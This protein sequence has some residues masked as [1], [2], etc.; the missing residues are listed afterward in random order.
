MPVPETIPMALTARRH[1]GRVSR[2]VAAHCPPEGVRPPLIDPFTTGGGGARA[3]ESG[4]RIVA[5]G[6]S[7]RQTGAPPKVHTHTHPRASSSSGYSLLQHHPFASVAPHTTGTV[8]LVPACTART[9]P[10]TSVP[11]PSLAPPLLLLLLPFLVPSSSLGRPKR[12]L[13]T[14]A[15][16]SSTCRP[17]SR[18]THHHA[19]RHVAGKRDQRHRAVEAIRPEEPARLP[20]AAVPRCATDRQRGASSPGPHTGRPAIARSRLEHAPGRGSGMS[21]GGRS[22]TGRESATADR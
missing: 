1:I 16:S 14:R 20:P 10:G 9:R 21:S 13:S 4:A 15:P 17:A 8:L 18:A 6:A 22:R 12:L 7:P 11:R 5:V 3:P 2:F 19:A